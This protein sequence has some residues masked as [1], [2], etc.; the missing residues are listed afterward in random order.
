M[1]I[2]ALAALYAGV[3]ALAWSKQRSFLFP[4]PPLMAPTLG[5]VVSFDGG[6]VLARSVPGA[7]ATVLFMHGNASQLFDWAAWL[8]RELGDRGLSFYA[9]EYPGY[10]GTPGEPNEQSVVEA[11]ERAAQ[12]LVT[13]KGVP[14]EQLILVGQSL[15]TGVAVQL[16]EK[17]WGERVVL[18]TPYTSIADAAAEGLPELPVRE[19]LDDR[20]DSLARAPKVKQPVLIA[21]GTADEIVPYAQGKTLAAAFPHAALMTVPAA[22]HFDIWLRPQVIDAV[23]RFAETGAV[24]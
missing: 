5:E 19:L 1:L 20:F 4:A 3:V 23:V 13:T 15:G 7:R 2:A 11:A 8:S 17:G 6:V 16:A 21:H 9:V 24:P 12:W 18:I 14:R 22:T 10:G